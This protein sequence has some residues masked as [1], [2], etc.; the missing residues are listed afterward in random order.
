MIENHDYSKVVDIFEYFNLEQ[1][2]ICN[3]A[4]ILLSVFVDFARE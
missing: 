1:G 2:K 4:M 3:K